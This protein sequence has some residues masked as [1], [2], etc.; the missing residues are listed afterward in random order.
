MGLGRRAKIP[1]LSRALSAPGGG[2]GGVAVI[3]VHSLAQAVAVL[4]AAVQARRPVILASAPGAGVYAGAAWFAELVA[5]AREAVPDAVCSIVLDAGD[6]PAA[7]LV[8]IRRGVERVVFT[9]RA[10]V[11]AR[12]ADVAAQYGVRLKTE[13]PAVILDLAPWFLESP[14]I[15]ERRCADLL[16][17]PAGF[18]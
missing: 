15:V 18:C 1:R 2:E 13:R 12:L 3:V 4:R 6:D 5:A 16:A 17:S 8:A 14:D 11:A 7:A 9:G 10:D